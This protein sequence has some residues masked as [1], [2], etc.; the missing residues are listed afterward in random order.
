MP[1]L[2]SIS[3]TWLTAAAAAT[4]MTGLAA[5]P[6]EAAKKTKFA[7]RCETYRK[8]FSKIQNYRKDQAVKGALLGGLAGLA[9]GVVLNSG[10]DN[11]KSVL[12]YV[13]GGAAAG[14]VIGYVSAKAQQARDREE[15]QRAIA[16]DFNGEVQNYEPLA[17]TIADLGNCRREQIYS[18]QADYEAK[19]IDGAEA[20]KRLVL[21]ESWVAKDDKAISGAADVQSER[22]AYYVQAQRLA[23]GARPEET[24]NADANFGYYSDARLQPAIAVSTVDASGAVLTPAEAPPPPFSTLYVSNRAGVNLRQQPNTA[25]AKLAT[26]PY[27]AAAQV[28]QSTTPGWYEVEWNGQTGYA[29]S[30]FFDG[31]LP[32][33]VLVS[34]PAPKKGVRKLQITKLKGDTSTPRAQASTAVASRSAAQQTRV[35][36]AAETSAQLS[37]LRSA[38][39]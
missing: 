8:P 18:V 9:T 4:V 15:V 7:D 38:L 27:R 21:L 33:R 11:K 22:I 30:S 5:S 17:G 24:E 16:S 35:R 14:G 23:E 29:A 25:A 6:A 37:D 1:V 36:S 2:R 10:R 13:I 28:R 32:P 39:T 19:L 20:R 26:L 3:R 31:T 34:A 12:P